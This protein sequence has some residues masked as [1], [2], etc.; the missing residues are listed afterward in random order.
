MEMPGLSNEVCLVLEYLQN[1]RAETDRVELKILKGKGSS[2]EVRD[3]V[4]FAEE[5]SMI[6][7]G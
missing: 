2:I 5:R 4:G 1:L 7:N 6:E 3:P